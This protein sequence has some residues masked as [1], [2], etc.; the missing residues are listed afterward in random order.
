LLT[1]KSGMLASKSLLLTSKSEM[2]ASKSLLLIADVRAKESDLMCCITRDLKIGRVIDSLPR[3]K[4][5]RFKG[6][7]SL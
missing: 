4:D 7:A 1:S 6:C 2:L 3:A 5:R